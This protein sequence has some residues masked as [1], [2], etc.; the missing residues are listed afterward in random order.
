MMQISLDGALRQCVRRGRAYA[1]VFVHTVHSLH[2]PPLPHARSNIAQPVATACTSTFSTLSV[3]NAKLRLYTFVRVTRSCCAG[4]LSSVRT[5][6]KT[7][8]NRTPIRQELRY[9]NAPKRRQRRP[10]SSI[11]ASES[12]C[13]VPH[14]SG[15]SLL[16]DE[17]GET[18]A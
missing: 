15:I 2:A 12:R 4:R 6:C 17:S 10:T 8:Y 1:S 11:P 18:A 13:T 16:A 14:S 3:R 7:A 9:T 5:V